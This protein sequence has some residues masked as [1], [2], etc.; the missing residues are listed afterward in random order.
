[1]GERARRTESAMTALDVWTIF[2]HPLD[3]PSSFVVRRASISATGI[4]TLDEVWLFEDLDQCRAFIDETQPGLIM[5]PR[6]P[7]DDPVIV[8]C[9]M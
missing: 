4:A 7:S 2:D 5:F 8:E 1:M 9:W 6:D 3:Y